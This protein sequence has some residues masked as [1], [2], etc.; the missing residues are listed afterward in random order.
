MT[1][2]GGGGGGDGGLG[3]KGG[4]GGGGGDGGA[5]DSTEQSTALADAAHEWSACILQSLTNSMPEFVVLVSYV[6]M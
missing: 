1:G 5:A 6:S 2:V 3:G 4:C